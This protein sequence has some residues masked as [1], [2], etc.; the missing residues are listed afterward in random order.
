MTRRI[1][2]PRLLYR[3]CGSATNAAKLVSDRS[4]KGSLKP[5]VL[6]EDCDRLALLMDDRCHLIARLE[7]PD[8]A[9]ARRHDEVVFDG[10]GTGLADGKPYP[11]TLEI[12]RQ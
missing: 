11:G 3:T 4:L 5:L 12:T 8:D 7:L 2:R 6:D 9:S 1:G 10:P